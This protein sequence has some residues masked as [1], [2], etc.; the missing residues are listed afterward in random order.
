[1]KRNQRSTR[2]AIAALAAI[3]F[4]GFT[5]ACQDGRPG[6][7]EPDFHHAPDHAK[8]GKGDG[9]GSTMNF[10]VGVAG[11]MV[12][13]GEEPQAVA[14]NVDDTDTQ[15]NIGSDPSFMIAVNFANTHTAA[16]E[17]LAN[18]Q[19]TDACVLEVPKQVKDPATLSDRLSTAIDQLIDGRMMGRNTHVGVDKTALGGSSD[20][21]ALGLHWNA[22]GHYDLRLGFEYRDGEGA[23]TVNVT[24]GDINAVGETVLQ[25]SGGWVY[26]KDR[27]RPSFVVACRNLDE[28]QVTIVR[29]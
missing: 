10:A 16:A 5:L 14:G 24:S 1:M 19:A 3:L 26:V 12:T 9:G 18:G 28:A 22:D 11:A 2:P 15:L 21:H 20:T 13:P 17:W 8:G 7:L 23:A 25:Y 29:G 6:P 27:D 4:A